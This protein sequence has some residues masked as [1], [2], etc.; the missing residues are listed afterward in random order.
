MSVRRR[1]RPHTQ[2]LR[3]RHL[4]SEQRPVAVLLERPVDACDKRAML[5]PGMA[6][7]AAATVTL[8]LARTHWFTFRASRCRRRR[9]A[10][11]DAARHATHLHRQGAPYLVSVP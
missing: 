8:I 3:G 4:E 7:F 2:R 1:G 11:A 5:G 6:A 9:R 10:S